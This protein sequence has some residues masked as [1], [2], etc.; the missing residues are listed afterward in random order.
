VCLHCV[1]ALCRVAGKISVNGAIVQDLLEGADMLQ[2]QHVVDACC[3]FLLQQ[4]HESNCI[5]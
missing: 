5:G 3:S 2:L 1:L 4:L